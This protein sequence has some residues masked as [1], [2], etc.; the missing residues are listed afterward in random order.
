MF[1]KICYKFEVVVMENKETNFLLTLSIIGLLLLG[2]VGSAVAVGGSSNE[3]ANFIES[4]NSR[5]SSGSEAKIKNVIVLVPDGCSQ[6]VQTLARW[7]SG[8]PL[9]LDGMV[10]GTVSTYSSDSVITDSSS[11]ATAFATG[12]KTT[13]G[14]VSVGPN[15]ASILTT[16]EQPSDELQYSPLATVLEGSKLEG[17]ATG[18]VATSRVTHATPAA[19]ASH[20]DN[21]DNENEIMEQMVYED[22]DVVFGGGSRHLL[23]EAE[24]GKRTDGE[25]LT[26]VLLDKGYQY[27]DSRD[28][29]LNL[30]SGK[31]W[32]LFA[33]SHMAPDI[34]R[35]EIAPQ[36]PS[37]SEMTE[38]AIELLSQDKDGFF[39]MVEGSQVDWANHANDPV[40]A[41]TDFLAFEEA[42]KIAIDF[43]EKDGHTLVLAFPDHNTGGMTIGSYSDSN[44]TSTTIEDVVAPLKNMK[45]S[46]TGVAAKIGTDLSPENI[47]TQLKIWWS[48][49]A[50][51]EDI[52]EI[53][54]LHNNGE[55]LSLDYAISEVI[56]K[57]YTVIGWTTH[58]HSGE[59][60]P[61]WTYGPETPA[62]HMD[63]T[64]IAGY[65][66]KESGFN[67]NETT[68]CLFVEAGEVFFKDNGDGQLNENE[69]LLDT[70]NSSNSVLRI[71]DVELPVNKNI[72]IKDGA[73][74]ELDGIVVYAPATDKVYFPS[75]V[76]S[77]V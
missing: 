26:G 37:L 11:A 29:L 77:L 2:N 60:V 10:A 59:D 27:V 33:S 69:Y 4:G 5:S 56:S 17:K 47:K 65:I 20:V 73:V 55:G 42:V 76:S 40:Y 7:Y 16:L 13:N 28:E 14:F 15:N 64:E 9:Q 18:L 53:L 54:E 41:V 62:G 66:A 52:T 21:R 50:T 36:E 38:K 58:G 48:I 44:Y 68:S 45:L 8:K 1:S 35:T 75:E 63:N 32:G 61:L 34:D 39:L 23:P 49:D 25:N 74:H 6:S 3:N 70:T 30:S 72:L 22:I 31:T 12:Y 51:D 24:G 67:L 46:S 57:N 19:F 71:G 43:A